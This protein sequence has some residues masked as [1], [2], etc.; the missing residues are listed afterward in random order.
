M[1]SSNK[2]KEISPDLHSKQ[3]MTFTFLLHEYSD[4]KNSHKFLWLVFWRFLFHHWIKSR[5]FPR[6]CCWAEQGRKQ[7]MGRT[8]RT[9]ERPER[10]QTG[11]LQGAP[12]CGRD[13]TY[14]G[15]LENHMRSW[16]ETIFKK[17]LPKLIYK[18]G[19]GGP[20]CLETCSSI[21]QG[22]GHVPFTGKACGASVGSKKKSVFLAQTHLAVQ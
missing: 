8:G 4:A 14:L 1:L 17:Y 7:Q 18:K 16:R 3:K 13:T 5:Y 19:R 15:S 6:I 20:K 11:C 10:S 22:T 2:H 21:I 9:K 12:P